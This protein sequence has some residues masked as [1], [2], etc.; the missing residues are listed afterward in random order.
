MRNVVVHYYAV[1]NTFSNGNENDFFRGER[2]AGG[3]IQ[4]RKLVGYSK[5][6]T[7]KSKVIST[8]IR[9]DETIKSRVSP[10]SHLKEM[11]QLAKMER[12]RK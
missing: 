3:K 9:T 10:N 4:T 1:V 12:M 6:E 11:W 8:L 7:T 2:G 5:K